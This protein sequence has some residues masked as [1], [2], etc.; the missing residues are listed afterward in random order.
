MVTQINPATSVAIAAV[1]V[2]PPA[3]VLQAT[4]ADVVGMEAI[5]RAVVAEVALV[6]RLGMVGMTMLEE[7]E[8]KDKTAAQAIQ[9]IDRV[10]PEEKSV[11]E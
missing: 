11:L 8:E 9:V 3:P 6:A 7:R 1:V 10:A 2:T 4:M 5:A